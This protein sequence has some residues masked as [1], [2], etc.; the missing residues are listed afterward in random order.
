MAEPLWAWGLHS[1]CQ[2]LPD[3]QRALAADRHQEGGVGRLTERDR[4][5]GNLLRQIGQDRSEGPDP[6][7]KGSGEGRTADGEVGTGQASVA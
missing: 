7:S 1:G 5:G 2:R 4:Q 6:G 3:R